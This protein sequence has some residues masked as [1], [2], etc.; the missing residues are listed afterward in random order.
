MILEPVI[1]EYGAIKNGFKSFLKVC[2]L[3]VYRVKPFGKVLYINHLSV[4]Y[5]KHSF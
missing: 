1:M 4:A 3:S 2:E 5:I